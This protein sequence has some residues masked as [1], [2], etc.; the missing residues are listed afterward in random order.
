MDILIVDD[1]PLARNE[2]HY[3]LSDIPQISKIEEAENIEE[4]LEHLLY[5][6]FDIVFLDINLMDES[7]IDL[8]AKIKKMKQSP[9]IIFATAHDTFAVK[10]FELNATDYILKPFERERIEK[11]IK[12]VQRTQ[13]VINKSKLSQES[14]TNLNYAN[15]DQT[16]EP[17]PTVIPIEVNERIHVININE[18]VA[19]TVN[20]GITTI[21]TIKNSFETTE[22]LYHYENKLPSEQFVKIHRSSIVN[23]NHI[24]TVEQWFN[25]T[26]Q[27]TMV[28]NM[29]LQVSR[30]YMKTFK[31]N[32]G[33]D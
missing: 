6:E 23:K 25:Y 20:N 28:N 8:A 27:I 18:I 21:S 26:Y 30:S 13:E 7:G 1:E 24:E 10:A 22:K 9:Y 29:K 4:T 14:E 19:I 3:L 32:I 12:K 11:A 17:H 33:L 2:L 15:N 16:I 31:Q 5:N